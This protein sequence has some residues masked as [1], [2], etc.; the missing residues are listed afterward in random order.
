MVVPVNVKSIF[1]TAFYMDPDFHMLSSKS[2]LTIGIKSKA[3]QRF[4]AAQCGRF[5]F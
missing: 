1:D 4:R 2:S 3:K 5:I